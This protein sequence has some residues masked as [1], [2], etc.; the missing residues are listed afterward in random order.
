MKSY[1]LLIIILFSIT[2]LILNYY[3]STILSEERFGV[4]AE[5]KL[6]RNQPT[7]INNGTSDGLTLAMFGD[8]P[9]TIADGVFDLVEN[10]KYTL[11]HDSELITTQEFEKKQGG[12]S[13][14]E[15]IS[16][17]TGIQASSQ[18]KLTNWVTSGTSLSSYEGKDNNKFKQQD[19][20]NSVLCQKLCDKDPKCNF[21]EYELK[22]GNNVNGT[23]SF[24]TNVQSLQKN[25]ANKNIISG[26][27]N[28]AT[29]KNNNCFVKDIHP[30]PDG[31]GTPND[32]VKTLVQY[33]ND[34][35]L[36]AG[37]RP[38]V[39]TYGAF[40]TQSA[41]P[42]DCQRQCQGNENCSYFAWKGDSSDGKFKNYCWL[43]NKTGGKDNANI[44]TSTFEGLVTGPKYCASKNDDIWKFTAEKGYINS[45]TTKY[46]DNY[47]N[48]YNNE[49]VII[50]QTKNLLNCQSHCRKH[51]TASS[52]N[53][54]PD[55][56]MCIC[57]DVTLS[58][59]KNNNNF[60]D[61]TQIAK[62]IAEDHELTQINKFRNENNK[63]KCPN[64]QWLIASK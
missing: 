47:P 63:E 61:T 10:T 31:Y 18:D 48:K 2:L 29:V 24:Y 15:C 20:G 5:N 27:S 60:L 6:M 37:Q 55:C 26:R 13:D 28:C 23:C 50:N 17:S 14:N 58:E 12:S 30:H 22:Q 45:S 8:I 59:A 32:G 11:P 16:Y 42:Q 41:S 38:V 53:Y 46:R 36:R 19:P 34:E 3:Y 40:T 43:F 56:K 4:V 64:D 7:G 52:A 57:K 25:T 33:D 62:I 21:Y 51:S 49:S 39:G 44:S 35:I 54:N 9:E 1:L